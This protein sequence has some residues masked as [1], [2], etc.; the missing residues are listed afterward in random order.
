MLSAWTIVLIAINLFAFFLTGFD[1]WCAIRRRR[2]VSES[3]LFLV[4]AAFGSLG[5]LLGM[6]AFHHKTKKISFQFVLAL[7]LFV[8]IGLLAWFFS[9][10]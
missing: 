3:T 8:Q 7:I 2:R 1:K 6:Y 9:M 4:A 10:L 5:V